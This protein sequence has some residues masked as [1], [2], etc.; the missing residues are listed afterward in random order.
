MSNQSRKSSIGLGENCIRKSSNT[1]PYNNPNRNLKRLGSNLSPSDC[2]HKICRQ[3]ANYFPCIFS[4]I[5]SITG[6]PNYL[7]VRVNLLK[8]SVTILK[9]KEALKTHKFFFAVD[10]DTFLKN[11]D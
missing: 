9:I 5:E 10:E 2:L 3:F 6:K 4:N 7:L 1:D 11:F 8:D